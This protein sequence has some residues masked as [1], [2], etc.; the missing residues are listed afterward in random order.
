MNAIDSTPTAMPWSSSNRG[1]MRGVGRARS[2]RVAP[3]ILVAALAA[4][5]ATTTKF[6]VPVAGQP[7]L[8]VDELRDRSDALLRVECPRL[9]QGHPSATGVARLAVTVGPTGDVMRAQ[10]TATSGDEGMDAIFGALSAQL[11]VQAPPAGRAE[12]GRLRLGYSC[13]PAAVATTVELNK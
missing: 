7:R 13:S 3:A 12:E 11:T 9:L 4:C 1:A 6:Y 2:T 10:I 8:T 5:V